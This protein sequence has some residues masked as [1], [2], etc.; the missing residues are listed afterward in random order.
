MQKNVPVPK[1]LKIIVNIFEW[2]LFLG[3]ITI[4][5]VMLSPILPTNKYFQTF[6][7]PSG[8]MEPTIHIGSI[9][10]VQTIKP[11][12]LQKSD[13]IAFIDPQDPKQIIL[14]RIESI[15]TSK[16][17][18]AIQT[19]GDN[20]NSEDAWKVG[21]GLIKGKMVVAFPYLG[22]VGQAIK[23]P[24]G[25]GLIIGIPLILL[26]LLQIKKIKEGIEEEVARRTQKALPNNSP[27]IGPSEKI[28]SLIFTIL[29]TLSL[30]F[31]LNPAKYANALFSSS[32]NLN[33]VTF[34]IENLLTPT[35]THS[36]TPS[37]SPT[38]CP[39]GSIEISGNGAGSDNTV[40]VTCIDTTIINQANLTNLQTSINAA[41]DTGGNGASGNT[42][43]STSVGSGSSSIT[44]DV[45]TIG[46][47]NKQ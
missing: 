5:F 27:Q 22:Y 7:V 18:M 17:I 16:G 9:A 24:L 19:K 29:G 13:I 43:G 14:H 47:S 1:F 10:L 42:G 21:S 39:P 36:P 2:L 46:A 15:D 38:S 25:F 35:P 6:I 8:S 37:P 30:I 4:G 40:T 23:T 3:L 28:L 32:V 26:I 41:A 31:T 45:Q 20:N 34:S 44:V 12:N 11:Q 33:N